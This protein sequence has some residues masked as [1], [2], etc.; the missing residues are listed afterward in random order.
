[1]KNWKLSAFSTVS[2][3]QSMEGMLQAGSSSKL[4]GRSTG[5]ARSWS[6]S[7]QSSQ[8]D[9]PAFCNGQGYL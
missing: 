4:T 5:K 1:M 3:K 2:M 6:V 7:S 8:G 9:A